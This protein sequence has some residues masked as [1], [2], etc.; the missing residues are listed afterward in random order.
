MPKRHRLSID[1]AF[2]FVGLILLARIL[3]HPANMTP[4]I[5][6]CLWAGRLYFK[7]IALLIVLSG[8]CISDLCVSWW[9]SFP[10]FGSWVLFNALSYTIIIFALSPVI[11]LGCIG[12]YGLVLGGSGAFWLISNLGVWLTGTMYSHDL[13][14]LTVCYIN[15]IPFLVLS[16]IGDLFWMVVLSQ[17]IKRWLDLN[18][19]LPQFQSLQYG[20]PVQLN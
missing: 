19:E 7:P 10:L 11:R 12:N 6:V 18:G 15:A 9:F 8:Y 13:N 20:N 17:F 14:G 1:L 3:P 4:I 2:F 16:V 5:S